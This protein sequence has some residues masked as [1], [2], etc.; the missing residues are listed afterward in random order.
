MQIGDIIIQRNMPCV[1]RDGVTLYADIYMPSSSEEVEYPVLLMRQPYGRALASTVSYAHP[2][3]YASQGYIVVI[4]DVRGRGE[5]E[6]IFDPFIHEAEDGYDTVQWAAALS[7]SNGKVGMYGFS[8]QGIT[9]WAAASLKPSSLQA[10]APSMCP[11]DLYEGMFYP[12]GSFAIGDQLPWAFQLARDTAI[13]AEDHEAAALCSSMMRNREAEAW[14]MPLARKHPV[15]ERYFP[16][17]YDWL[18]HREYDAYWEDRNYLKHAADF[19]IPTLHIAG[20]Y[21]TFL[22]G[23]LSSYSKLQELPQTADCFHR[24]IIG[25][26]THIPWGRYAGGVDHGEQAGGQI[27]E[28][29]IRW[30]DYWLKGNRDNGLAYEQPVRYFEQGSQAWR[31]SE[32]IPGYMSHYADDQARLDEASDRWYLSGTGNPANG[33]LGGGK[34]FHSSTEIQAA[35]PDVF[36]YDSRL[37][38]RLDSYS[39]VNRQIQQ[40]RYEILVYTS[41]AL[42]E[43]ISLFGAPR[44]SAQVQTM[45]G[46]T[47]LVAILTVVEPDGAAR[48]LSVGRTEI[49]SESGSASTGWIE[50]SITMRPIAVKLQKGAAIRLELTGSA[51]PLFTRHPNG[52]TGA[53]HTAR[54]T[55]LRMATVAVKSSR[56]QESY[57]DLPIISRGDTLV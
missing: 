35:A 1:M 43:E 5:S 47:D 19:Q 7:G 57:I 39:P 44:L 40:E 31:T 21:D 9:Q 22:M 54:E 55:E 29:H 56:E 24:M 37:P 2:I 8:Y 42:L 30:F 27:H 51:F 4:Q 33:A 50:A 12:H 10:I 6:G 16:V 38:M 48:L 34:L 49:S 26:W 18:A 11:A 20:W 14:E 52:V 28:A 36:V 32:C 45:G 17:Y 25:P 23:S 41:D 53:N 13:R 3:W 46:P 15:L